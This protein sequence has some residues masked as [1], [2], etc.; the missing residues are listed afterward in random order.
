M[1]NEQRDELL[2]SMKE[3]MEQRDKLLLSMKESIDR[4]EEKDKQKDEILLS[5]KESMEKR[6]ELLLSMINKVDEKCERYHHEVLEELERQR[7]NMVKLEHNLTEQIRA[8][9]DVREINKDKFE[10]NDVRFTS[11]DKT[12]DWHHRRILNLETK[13]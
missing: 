12:L 2:L 1:T 13:N 6:D 7:L 11:I 4:L 8:L 9:F 10:E 5:M 3:S